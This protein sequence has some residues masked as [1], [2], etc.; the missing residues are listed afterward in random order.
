[1]TV[2]HEM[3]IEITPSGKIEVTVKGAKGKKCMDYV[4]IFQSIGK[5]TE[6]QH[7]SEFYEPEQTVNLTDS[8]RNRFSR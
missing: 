3:E 8:I 6:E 4:Q 2:R 1:M 7:T 5:I